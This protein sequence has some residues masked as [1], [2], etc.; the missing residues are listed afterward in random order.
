MITAVA[1]F[2]QDWPQWLGPNRDGKAIGFTAPKTW[3]K[4]L[5]QKWKTTVGLGDATP[6]LVG[7]KVYVFAKQGGDEVILCL[8]AADGKEVWRDKYPAIAISGADGQHAGPRSSPAVADGKV[9]TLGAG[10]VLSCLDAASGKLLW[11]KAGTGG[12][13][14]F[15][16]ASS[17][18]IVDGLCIVQLGGSGSGTI[19]AFDLATGNEKWKSAGDAPAYGSP[20]VVTVEGTKQIVAQ[21]SASLVGVAAADGKPL[22]KIAAA[23]QGMMSGYNAVTPI[24]DGQ[25][26]IY[27]GQGAG[28]RAVKIEKQGDQFTTKE[29]WKSP[30][31]TKYNTPVLKD[32]LLYGYSQSNGLFCMRAATGEVAWKSPGG[33]QGFGTVVDAG[34]VVIALPSASSEL[35][36]Y[37]PT[38]KKFDELARIKVSD[39]P[40]YTFP[41]VSGNRIFVKSRDALTMWTVE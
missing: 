26:V 5:T 40:T 38:D 4:A 34:P 31:G 1:A 41:I 18:L 35:I 20:V 19:S 14:R 29:V 36:A 7:D 8:T 33:G 10:G 25:T 22:W 28:T 37:S 3:P 6:A 27:T 23:T 15:H 12:F 2:G 21:T 9:V 32:G 24:I 17:P 39:T 30:V 13:P 11:R 16:V